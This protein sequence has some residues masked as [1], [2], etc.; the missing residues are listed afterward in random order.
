M[1]GP[2]IGLTRQQTSPTEVPWNTNGEAV[3]AWKTHAATR[4]APVTLRTYTYQIQRFAAAW[5]DPLWLLSHQDIWHYT[6]QYS[7]QCRHYRMQLGRGNG[8]G[9]T[10][11][12][13]LATCNPQCPTY[14]AM[15]FVTVDAHLQAIVAFYDYLEHLGAVDK[16]PARSVKREWVRENRHRHRQ[17]AKRIPNAQ[18]IRTLLQGDIQDNHRAVYAVM[19]KTG[20]RSSE[21]LSLRIDPQHYEPGKWLRIPE[22]EHGKRRGN[23][24]LPIDDE[25]HA[26]LQD[27][28]E[29]RNDRIQNWPH[30]HE[31][32]FIAPT[33]RRLAPGPDPSQTLLGFCKADQQ[34]TG[35]A[36]D[37]PPWRPHA[38]R[39]FFS[40][41]LKRNG[42]DEY[43]WNILRGDVPRGNL[44]TYV[45]PTREDIRQQ[46]DRHAPKLFA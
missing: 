22:N 8:P 2:L 30:P 33:G 6:T 9:C 20:T 32:L 4:L 1:T 24:W 31:Y 46:Y 35:L 16:N 28:L 25:L 7:S 29:W 15:R 45:H 27:Y 23:R 14:Q 37:L 38:F 43:W 5:N 12:Q 26:I 19:A 34:R 18:E 40:D 41:T 3:Q 13:D 21:A 17:R 42:C 11:G 36:T 39:H 10:Q 44:S